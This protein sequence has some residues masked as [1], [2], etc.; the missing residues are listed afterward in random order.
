MPRWSDYKPLDPL[1]TQTLS[2]KSN[3]NEGDTF[4]PHEFQWLAYW[5]RHFGLKKENYSLIFY[6]ISTWLSAYSWGDCF[7]I[8]VFTNRPK[9]SDSCLAKFSKQTRCR[10]G[11]KRAP[12]CS[13]NQSCWKACAKAPREK[14]FFFFFTSSAQ[15]LLP[16]HF[17]ITKY[18]IF[19][20]VLLWFNCFEAKWYD[21]LQRCSPAGVWQVNNYH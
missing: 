16:N 9:S 5:D 14:Y 1:A 15:A 12:P 17:L 13:G 18:C 6:P 3:T 21:S 4:I 20:Q 8:L 7:N 11:G 19:T 10:R 2:Q